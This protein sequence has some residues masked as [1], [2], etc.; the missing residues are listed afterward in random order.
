[1]EKSLK[2]KDKKTNKKKE[3]KK[4]DVKQKK[5]VKRVVDDEKNTLSIHEFDTDIET[6]QNKSYGIIGKSGSG[7]TI[8]GRFLQYNMREIPSA[9]VLCNAPK[10]AGFY[11]EYIPSENI[12]SDNQ[13]CEEQIELLFNRATNLSKMYNKYWVKIKNKFLDNY[14]EYPSQKPTFWNNDIFSQFISYML[15]RGN[16]LHI[17]KEFKKYFDL[18]KKLVLDNVKNGS[19]KNYLAIFAD[20]RTIII[21]DDVMSEKWFNDRKGSTITDILS[22][23]RHVYITSF[24]LM[25]NYTGLST[26]ARNN[27]SYFIVMGNVSLFNK[28]YE[29]KI[30]S[31]D[32]T[33]FKRGK[34]NPTLST[35]AKD[36]MSKYGA[37]VYVNDGR[38]IELNDALFYLYVPKKYVYNI[39]FQIGN[40]EDSDSD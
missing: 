23:G 40:F 27:F 13:A 1:M 29:E 12:F 38:S 9:Y 22:R 36:I 31:I 14:A 26:T 24:F 32:S 21:F 33:K 8:M 34:N 4:K 28:L 18:V 11:G 5:S 7:K 16:I 10:V 3:N 20:C 15:D 30:S 19:S 37:I 6:L 2:K 35:Y 25:Q 39:K 17:K